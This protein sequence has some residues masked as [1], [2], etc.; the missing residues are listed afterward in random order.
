MKIALLLVALMASPAAAQELAFDTVRIQVDQADSID[1]V[2][3]NDDGRP[4]LVITGGRSARIFLFRPEGGF[5]PAPDRTITFGTDA[6]L[7]TVGKFA[8]A[9]GLQIVVFTSRGVQRYVRTGLAE[10]RGP[11]DL[12]IAPNLFHGTAQA[13][14]AP[15]RLDFMKDLD[16]DGLSDVL[17]LA[18]EGLWIFPQEKDAGG[19]PR[20]RLKQKLPVPFGA[21]MESQWGPHQK[22]SQLVSIPLIAVGDANKDGRADLVYLYEGTLGQFFQKADGRFEGATGSLSAGRA[23]PRRHYLKFEA[24][25]RLVDL[26]GDGMLDVAVPDPFKGRVDIYFNRRGRPD[27]SSADAVLKV[28]DAYSSGIYVE[29]LDG[30]GKPEIVMGV[31]HKFG[32]IGGIQTF[33]SGKIDLELHYHRLEKGTFTNSPV[34]QLTFSVP[35][36]FHATR[37]SAEPD[38]KFWPELKADLDGD[39]LRDLIVGKGDRELGVHFGRKDVL[40]AAA[41]GAVIPFDPPDGTSS[42]KTVVADFNGDGRSDL[43]FKYERVERRDVVID[44]KISRKPK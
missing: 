18:P 19:K 16:G 24:P 27:F 4:D 6:Y 13:E 42:T 39:G 9:P 10:W 36:T 3:L 35:F 23:K 33:I 37:D 12:I 2:D 15:L 34:Q 38:L 40:V 29:D 8:D 44:V 7:W 26:D 43:V 22:L 20:F 1:A 14:A 31:I 41:E 32:I 30:D 28:E 5:K 17:F 11:E 21:G 25:P